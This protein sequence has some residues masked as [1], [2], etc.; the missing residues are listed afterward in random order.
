M[1]EVYGVNMNYESEVRFSHKEIALYK[2]REGA[3]NA[4]KEFIE[5][6]LREMKG[7]NK[8]DPKGFY[9]IDLIDQV[10][11][12]LFGKK[13]DYERDLPLYFIKVSNLNN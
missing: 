5:T 13:D 6:D 7:M 4:I 12:N 3:E 2:T 11:K 1:T 9:S 10:E 8:C